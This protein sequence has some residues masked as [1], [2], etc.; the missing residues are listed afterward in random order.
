[1]NPDEESPVILDAF[2][3]SR[4]GRGFRLDRADAGPDE[5]AADIERWF[6]PDCPE[7]RNRG[8]PGAVHQRGAGRG[9][10]G[11]SGEPGGLDGDVRMG[12]GACSGSAG[13]GGER[14]G[15]WIG[16]CAAEYLGGGED[17]RGGARGARADA[18]GLAGTAAA[19]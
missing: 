10:G 2:A 5:Q 16:S 18:D 13:A 19:G 14:S 11:D 1:M 7:V 3:A 12:E 6:L 8:R 4:Y 9:L 15:K 17:R